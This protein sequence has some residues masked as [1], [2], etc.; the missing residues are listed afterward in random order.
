MYMC[1]PVVAYGKMGNP[2]SIPPNSNLIFEIEV[3]RCDPVSKFNQFTCIVLLVTNPTNDDFNMKPEDPIP[4][5]IQ[6]AQDQKD[7]GNTHYRNAQF[8]DAAAAYRSALSKLTYTWGADVFEIDT[9]S[10]LKTSLNSNLAAAC[11]KTGDLM[12][13]VEACE[14]AVE[15]DG[16]LVKAWFRMGQAKAGLAMFEQAVEALETAMKM[17]PADETIPKE[18]ER[19]K[20][21]KKELVEKEKKMYQAMFK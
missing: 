13:A 21:M 9:I 8:S 20:R 16:K 4:D 12:E 18:I 5:K 15:I 6:F 17:D 14:R 11:L 10:K 1:M 19:V 3:I 2:P 7:L